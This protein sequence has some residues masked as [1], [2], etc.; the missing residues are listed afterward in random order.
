MKKSLILVTL[1]LASCSD[2]SPSVNSFQVNQDVESLVEPFLEIY[3]RTVSGF[4]PEPEVSTVAPNHYRVISFAFMPGDG[5][6]YFTADVKYKGI[7][8]NLLISPTLIRLDLTYVP[9]NRISQ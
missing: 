5:L 9:N 2:D 6:M 7:G 1:L 3:G 4:Y 8:D